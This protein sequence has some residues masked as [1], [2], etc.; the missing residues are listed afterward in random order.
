MFAL[1]LACAA[2]NAT[3]GAPGAAATPVID[4]ASAAAPPAATPFD[5]ALWGD[6]NAEVASYTLTQPRYGN[7]WQGTATLIF[8]TEDFSW[9]ARVKADAG[10]HPPDDIRK[11]IKLNALRDFRTGIYDY[12][13]MTSTFARLEGGDGMRPLD[14]LKIAFSATEWC[15]M[16]YAELTPHPRKAVLTTH[17]YFDR[18]DVAPPVVPVPDDVVYGDDVPL[19][20]RGFLGEW[21]RPGAT[22]TAPYLPT[23]LE[24]RFAHVPLAVG[25]VHVTRGPDVRQD[26]LGTPTD[27]VEYNVVASPGEVST[28]WFVERAGAHRIVGWESSTG[29]SAALRGVD[30]LPYWQLNQPGG[31][32]H[33]TRI[34]L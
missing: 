25:S 22:L 23:L 26:V 9:S 21:L 3:A 1:L 14:P 20:I 7:I 12:D 11:V 15:G 30:R 13:V 34:G 27:V 8:V 19:L 2:E 33:R 10:Q 16:V 5:W 24:S 31:D 18:D 6:G 17:T 32:V 28:R 29:E 4:A